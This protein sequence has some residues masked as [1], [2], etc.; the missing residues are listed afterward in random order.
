MIKN[1]ALLRTEKIMEIIFR[2]HFAMTKESPFHFHPHSPYVMQSQ[3]GN[4]K[5][6]ERGR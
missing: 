5:D 1:N 3:Y 6:D 4:M 2:S